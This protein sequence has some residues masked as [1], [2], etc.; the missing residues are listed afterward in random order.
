MRA[1]VITNALKRAALASL[2]TPALV[3]CGSSPGA[4]ASSGGSTASTLGSSECADKSSDAGVGVDPP[5]VRSFELV[6][7]A[8]ACDP[9]DAGEL[10]TAQCD[11]L[12]APGTPVSCAGYEKETASYVSCYYGA[13]NTGRRP[14]G[15]AS[16]R[17]RGTCATARFLA[18]AAFLEAASV[19]AFERLTRELRAHRAPLHLCVASRRAER[20][21]VRHARVIRSLAER[22][23]GC[24]PR[25]R[26]RLGAVRPIEQ[27]AIENVVE[28]CVRETFGAAVAII[29]AQRASDGRARRAMK[30][31]ARDEMRH[32]RL[33]WAVAAWLD[34]KLDGRARARVRRA[35][36]KAVEALM[37]SVAVEQ[38]P[39]VSKEL[40]LPTAV[41][42]RV[43]L[44]QLQASLWS[45]SAA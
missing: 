8:S 37:R 6:G 29:Q 31:I 39:D 34:T 12:C 24:V 11:E 35:R 32:A 25:C 7:L 41:Q 10:T 5:C 19:D 14:E 20:D 38:A 30:P 28:G 9:D 43:V 2:A 44:E 33:S 18:E 45:L 40:G 15:L 26:V 17:F 36:A 3:S 16:D 1:S 21:E 4:A 27:M 22:A 23:G 13:C 42:A